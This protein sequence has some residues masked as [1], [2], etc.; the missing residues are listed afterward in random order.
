MVRNPPFFIHAVICCAFLNHIKMAQK[1]ITPEIK[2]CYCGANAKI[3][4]WEDYDIIYQVV[5]ENRH[6]LSKYCRT[7]HRAICLWNNRVS[8]H[9]I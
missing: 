7:R 8:Q 5:C 3:Q 9:S 1:I 2:K 4:T 6:T